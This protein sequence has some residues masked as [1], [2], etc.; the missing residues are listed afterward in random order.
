MHSLRTL[1]SFP[2]E[3]LRRAFVEAFSDYEVKIDM[4]PEKFAEFLLVRGFRPE[5]S[6][7]A[8]V[9]GELSGF[10]LVGLRELEGLRTGYDIATGVLPSR[11]RRGLGDLLLEALVEKLEGGALE[12]F[13]L[14]VLEHNEG[15][16]ALYEMHGFRV[17]RRLNCYARSFEGEAPRPQ[18]GFREGGPGLVGRLRSSECLPFR[19]SWQN[20]FPSYANSPA[21]FCLRYLEEGG[22][23]LAYGIVH[24]LRGEVLQAGLAPDWRGVAAGGAL[25][26]ELRAATASPRLVLLNVEAESWLDALLPELGFERTVGQFEMERRRGGT[27]GGSV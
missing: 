15:A 23:I 1:E 3:S 27:G 8:L 10:V 12:R 13:L 22:R 18:A 6:L 4:P 26:E 24:R 20:D 14:E 9:E 11:Q 2:V 19:P 16:R 21:G 5:A 25:V 17:L 7:G